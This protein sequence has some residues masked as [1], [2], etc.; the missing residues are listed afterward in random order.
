MRCYISV[1]LN[2]RIKQLHALLLPIAVNI[3]AIMNLDNCNMN[4]LFT[5]YNQ[6]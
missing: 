3:H 4:S 1:G 2:N 6:S 5:C